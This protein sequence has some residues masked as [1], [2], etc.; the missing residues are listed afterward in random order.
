MLSLR[1]CAIAS[2]ARPSACIV[3]RRRVSGRRR[4]RRRGTAMRVGGREQRGRVHLW[5]G[6]RCFC[7]DFLFRQT[8][9]GLFQSRSHTI[10]ARLERQ[11]L[12]AHGQRRRSIR[13]TIAHRIISFMRMAAARAAFFRGAYSPSTRPSQCPPRGC[14][15]REGGAA[16]TVARRRWHAVDAPK[17]IKYHR[18]SVLLVN[19]L[20]GSRS[21]GQRRQPPSQIHGNQPTNSHHRHTAITDCG[22]RSRAALI[23]GFFMTA[24]IIT[25]C[26][27]QLLFL[28]RLLQ[29][30]LHYYTEL[31]FYFETKT[32]SPPARSKGPPTLALQPTPPAPAPIT[33]PPLV[34]FHLALC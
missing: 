29:T 20:L 30:A 8:L 25:K 2:S 28:A 3:Q 31:Q 34:S 32:P 22:G 21:L 12:H 26:L 9:C 27:F 13:A 24:L 15:G 14:I 19:Q 4:R 6:R 5:R 23:N 17:L 18:K 1:E 33:P 10:A 16:A 7:P 11:G